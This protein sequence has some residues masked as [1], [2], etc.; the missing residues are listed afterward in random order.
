VPEHDEG[1]FGGD[2]DGYQPDS[3]TDSDADSASDS[4]IDS[5][6]YHSGEGA[7]RFPDDVEAYPEGVRPLIESWQRMRE[8][9]WNKAGYET[10]W[11]VVKE[12]EAGWER[13]GFR[14]KLRPRRKRPRSAQE[15]PDSAPPEIDLDA[16]AADAVRPRRARR[17]QVNVRLTELGYDALREAARAYGLRP[18]TLARLLIHRGALAVLERQKG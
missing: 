8:G 1:V 12:E 13:M 4:A 18:S 2:S 7:A 9:W 15:L 10:Y 11:E 17:R 3:A 6:G 5:D 14:S 16:L